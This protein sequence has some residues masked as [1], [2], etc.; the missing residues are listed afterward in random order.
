M[1]RWVRAIDRLAALLGGLVLVF[2]GAAA[3]VWAIG[4]PRAVADRLPARLSTRAITEAAN[5]PWWPWAVGLGGAAAGLLAVRLLLAHVPMNRAHPVTLPES[6]DRGRLRIDL[7]TIADAAAA[8][9]EGQP[10]IA[11]ARGTVRCDRG[12]TFIEISARL[13][14]RATLA[15]AAV[16]AGAVSARTGT[17]ADDAYV[18]TRVLLCAPRRRSA[19]P[20]VE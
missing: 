3:L 19:P 5:Q 6:D 20:R 18:A 11:A 1:S 10:C 15:E 8:D 14:P 16:A 9:L 7:R 12:R 4:W 13:T 17:L 2:G